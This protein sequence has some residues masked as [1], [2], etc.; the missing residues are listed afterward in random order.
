MGILDFLTGSAPE[1]YEKKADEFVIHGAYGHA[2]IEYEKAL[3]RL[4]RLSEVK[5][6]YRPLIE[7]KLHRCKESLAREHRQAGQSL[8]AAGCGDEARELF[9]LALELTKDARL[10]AD[11]TNLL[12]TIPAAS[13]PSDAYE[14][15]VPVSPEEDQLETHHPG[16]DEE[17]FEALCNSLEDAEHEAYHTY[18]DT[19]MKGF[20]AL[21]RGDFDT[22]VTLLAE[23]AGAYP[24]GANYITLELAT[25]H[26][27]RGENETA[28]AL[29]ESFLEEYPEAL[30]AYTLMCDI[31]WETEAFDDAQQLLAGCPAT[32]AESLPVKMLT[33]ETFMRSQQF[34]RAADLYEDLLEIYGWDPIVAQALA[35]TLEARGRN[36]EARDLYGEM[37]G[38]CTGCG[39]RVDPMVKQRYAET[40]LAAG[41]FSTKIL[42]LFLDLVQEDPV[43]RLGYYHRISHIY[44]LQ[45]NEHESRRFA[46]FAQRLAEEDNG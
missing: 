16:S 30:R 1:K 9:S 45:G 42:E 4:A 37:I 8:V 39:S 6:G 10:T 35:A 36:E 12:A 11:V 38:A 15:F 46:A 24:F 40:S 25:A 29:L 27:N 13:K 43:N 34:A 26:L 31:F 32:L 17:V 5:P 18:P 23:A 19:F 3:A 28:R 21:N 7:D 41:D 33:G 14:Y 44:S 20:V 2:K 22:A